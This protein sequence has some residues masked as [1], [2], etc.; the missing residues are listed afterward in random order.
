[1]D[2]ISK[3]RRS[4]NMSR[5]RSKDTNPEKLVRSA[6]RRL[7]YRFRT[8]PL[9]LPG[10]P[11]IVVARRRLLIFVHGCF[12]HRH[13]ACKFAYTPK[14][15]VSFWQKKFCQNVERDR[16]RAKELKKLGWR[17]SVIWECETKDLARL[18]RK[19]RSILRSSAGRS[20]QSSR[21]SIA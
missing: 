10:K 18:E 11:D 15:R 9:K 19:I 20:M 7:R 12:W 21:R 2:I 16:T 17:V 13:R 8:Y 4:W 1:M 14:S 6:L 5:I 3:E